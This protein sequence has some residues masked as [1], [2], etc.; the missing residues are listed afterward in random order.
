[1]ARRKWIRLSLL[2]LC[3]GAALVLLMMLRGRRPVPAGELA[4]WPEEGKPGRY[5]TRFEAMG[6]DARLEVAAPSLSAAR[7][8]MSAAVR[9]IRTVEERMSTYRPDSEISR[10]NRLGAVQAVELSAHTLRVLEAAARASELTGGAFDVTYAPLRT[11][12]RKASQAG[13]VPSEED[14]RQAVSCIGWRNLLVEGN[15]ARFLVPGM[16]VDLGGI[17]KGYAIELAAEA[18]MRAGARSGIVD[19]GGDLRLFGLPDGRPSWLVEV[20]RPPGVPE[21]I[22]LAVPPCGITTSGDYA[23]G[24]QVGDKSF[25]HIIDPRTGWPVASMASV[26]VVAP[27][28][29]TADGLSCG[30]SVMGP[31]R[32]IALV[33]SLPGIQCMMM[34][35]RPD[36]TVERH[37]SRG[38]AALVEGR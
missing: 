31:E 22:I 2:A 14:I 7:E 15:K 19:V 3:I 38:F 37:A 11:L 29:T 30:L 1:M 18:M 26:T 36:G 23:R 33:D 35:R 17:A 13:Q 24:F 32:G 5:E 6:T 20:K 10:L 27:D 34:V 8:M 16:E 28:T 12:W 4:V 25:S 21:Q 9:E